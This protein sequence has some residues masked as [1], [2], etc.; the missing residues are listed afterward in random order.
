MR[1]V[2]IIFTGIFSIIAILSLWTGNLRT[3]FS[4]LIFAYLS[5]MG[6]ILVGCK[7]DKSKHTNKESDTRDKKV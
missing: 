7:N 5:Y 1:V 4:S 2:F 6:I 3:V